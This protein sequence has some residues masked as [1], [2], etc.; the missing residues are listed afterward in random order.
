MRTATLILDVNPQGKARA[1]HG[2]GFTY[3][4]AS[5]RKS[6]SDYKLALKREFK[7]DPFDT[8][9]SLKAIFYLKKPK[10]VKRSFPSVKPDIDNI[11][12]KIMDC[13]N[14]ILWMDDALICKMNAE[15]KYTTGDG[16]IELK[17]EEMIL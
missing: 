6:D 1:K 7:E 10:S 17:L 16:Y 13:G 14:A 4:T 2:K 5:A 11:C 8:P 9:L 12:K 3:T 15:K